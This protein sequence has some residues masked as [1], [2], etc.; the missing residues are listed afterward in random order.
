MESSDIDYIVKRVRKDI[1]Q[2]RAKELQDYLDSQNKKIS[3]LEG[4]VLRWREEAYRLQTLINNPQTEEFLKAVE[5]EAAHQQ[6]RWKDTD[7]KKDDNEW[8]WVIGY[9]AGKALSSSKRIEEELRRD[10]A[11]DNEEAAAPHRKK[12]L[13]HLITTCAALLNWHRARTS[14]TGPR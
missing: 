6:E 9:L 13:H 7:N 2:F 12:F 8:F 5:L 1:G 14:L 4:E 3:E 10:D 11:P